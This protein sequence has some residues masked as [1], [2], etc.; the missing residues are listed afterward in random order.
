[1]LMDAQRTETLSAVATSESFLDDSF[2][3]GPQRWTEFRLARRDPVPRKSVL[4]TGRTIHTFR[5]RSDAG[6]RQVRRAPSRP[7]G[8]LC[9]ECVE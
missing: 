6:L 4:S 5:L 7:G 9:P 3:G 2:R 8:V 1:M